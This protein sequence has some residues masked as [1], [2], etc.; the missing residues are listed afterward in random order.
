MGNLYSDEET[1]NLKRLFDIFDSESTGHIE[2][3]DMQ[4]VLEDLGTSSNELISDVPSKN[5]G[6]LD[7]EEFLSC[8]SQ[9]E[10][11]IQPLEQYATLNDFSQ[12]IQEKTV[13]ADSRVLDFLR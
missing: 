12:Q 2:F 9:I 11:N 4:K 13:S 1:N 10:K 5:P 3:T 6:R 8:L 7:F